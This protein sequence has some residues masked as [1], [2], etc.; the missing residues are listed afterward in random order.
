MEDWGIFRY[1]IPMLAGG[2]GTLLVIWLVNRSSEDSS[3]CKTGAFVQFIYFI[4]I[5]MGCMGLWLTLVPN[6]PSDR[7]NDEVWLPWAMVVMIAVFSWVF[8]DS[9]FRE[10]TWDNNQIVFKKLGSPQRWASWDDL[11]SIR[12]KPIAQYWRIGF[13]DGS[14]FAFSEIMS[15][16]K[17]LLEACERHGLKLDGQ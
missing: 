10:I 15:D 4:G 5:V 17:T 7:L 3:R 2:V 13:K 11:T 8:L 14:G 1:I 16:S 9:L 6:D 12:Y